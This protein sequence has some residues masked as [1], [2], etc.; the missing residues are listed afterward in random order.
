[1]SRLNIRIAQGCSLQAFCT[2]MCLFVGLTMF[3]QDTGMMFN[4]PG[5][6]APKNGIVSM[7]GSH[8]WYVNKHAECWRHEGTFEPL[9][10]ITGPLEP[11][12]FSAL[13]MYYHLNLYQF[14]Q[15][16][17]LA[18]V[19]MSTPH[20]W[21]PSNK[22]KHNF[23][24]HKAYNLSKDTEAKDEASHFQTIVEANGYPSRIEHKLLHKHDFLF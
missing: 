9:Q 4:F 12:H 8:R 24:P 18:H 20:L 6:A 5:H 7:Y 1:M 22:D 3:L 17:F 11:L 23:I 21:S 15:Q 2:T 19:Q 14:L 16:N 10:R 13:R